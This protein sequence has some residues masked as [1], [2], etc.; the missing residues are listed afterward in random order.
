[1]VYQEISSERLGIPLSRA[2]PMNDP[3][4]EE[5]VI[6]LIHERVKE[7][8]GDVVVLVDACTIRHDVKDEVKEL[9]LATG[10]PVYAAPMGKSAI[11]ENYE[12]YGG[13][14]LFCLFYMTTFIYWL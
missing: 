3:L 13:V 8:Q 2:T 4:T 1:M 12:R 9:L 14:R 5:F 6:N 10:F 11:D 7:A